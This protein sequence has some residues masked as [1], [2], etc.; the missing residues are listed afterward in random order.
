MY[1]V[2]AF[3]NNSF[4]EVSDKIVTIETMLIHT[5][6]LGIIAFLLN[7]KFPRIFLLTLVITVFLSSGGVFTV[8]DPLIG[9][10]AVLE[11]GMTYVACAYGEMFVVFCSNILGLWLR[12]ISNKKVQN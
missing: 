1:F 6:V 3:S 10:H 2:F 5:L 9:K 12:N 4:A 7:Y 11:Q 8:H